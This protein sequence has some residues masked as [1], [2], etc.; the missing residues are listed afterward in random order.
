[1]C[2]P[3]MTNQPRKT[4]GRRTRIDLAVS[5]Y[6][7]KHCAPS[8]SHV[9]AAE[10]VYV[11]TLACRAAA[12]HPLP[13]KAASASLNCCMLMS[14]NQTQ[15]QLHL[16]GHCTAR[17]IPGSC[18]HRGSRRLCTLTT[19]PGRGAM[20]LYDTRMHVDSQSVQFSDALAYMTAAFFT[21]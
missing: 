7:S 3:V 6:M 9:T 5:P 10:G 2:M 4:I 21:Q 11:D 20:L 17:H 16:A 14:P 15:T 8:P 18:T 13:D 19:G 12:G 1:M